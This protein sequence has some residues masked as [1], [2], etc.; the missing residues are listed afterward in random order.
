[1]TFSSGIYDRGKGCSLTAPSDADKQW[2]WVGTAMR[3]MVGD[4]TWEQGRAKY[5][6][7]QYSFNMYCKVALYSHA[8]KIEK[9]I[10]ILTTFIV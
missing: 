4:I 6:Q 7:F 5:C 2:V 3:C 10:L 1:M 9:S 8:A